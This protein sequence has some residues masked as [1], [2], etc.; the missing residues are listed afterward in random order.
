MSTEIKNAAYGLK[1]PLI[2]KLSFSRKRE[3]HKQKK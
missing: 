3:S 1:K 2:V